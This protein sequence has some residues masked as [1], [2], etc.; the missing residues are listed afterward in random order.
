MSNKLINA[1][2]ILCK[3][4][5]GETKKAIEEASKVFTDESYGEAL[6]IIKQLLEAGGLTKELI[7]LHSAH[8]KTAMY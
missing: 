7:C 2:K 8:F 6:R 5:M 3:Q 4:W 1:D